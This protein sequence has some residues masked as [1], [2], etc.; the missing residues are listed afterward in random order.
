MDWEL[1]RGDVKGLNWN[2]IIRSPCP[3]LS[4]NEA[5]LHVIRERVPKWTIVVRTGGKPWSDDLY[6]LAHSAKQRA[7]RVWSHSKT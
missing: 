6:V 3:V 1:V 5:L 7:Y 4:Q 2:R